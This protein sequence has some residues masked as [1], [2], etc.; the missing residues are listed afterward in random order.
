MTLPSTKRRAFISY[1]HESDAHRKAVLT[2]SQRLSSILGDTTVEII[3]DQT[4]LD[5]RPAGP[6]EGWNRWS[7]NMAA[8]AERVIAIISPGWFAAM[9]Q[10]ELKPLPGGRG[11]AV[12]ATVI[13]NR[14]TDGRTVSPWLRL[15]RLPTFP[16]TETNWLMRDI[17]VFLGDNDADIQALGRWLKNTDALGAAEAPSAST[18]LHPSKTTPPARRPGPAIAIAAGAAAL[19]AGGFF[20]AKPVLFAAKDD[21]ARDQA[22]SDSPATPPPPESTPSPKPATH[23]LPANP[24]PGALGEVPLDA[25]TTLKLRWCPP[26]QFTMGR[27]QSEIQHL[28]TFELHDK[29]EER[30][31]SEVTVPAGFWIS[32]TE[33]TRKQ[34]AAIRSSSS[35]TAT[36]SDDFPAVGLSHPDAV[37]IGAELTAKLAGS[38][39]TARLPNNAEWEYACRAGSTS[40]FSFGDAIDGTRA[41]YDA[42][43]TI[44]GSTGKKGPGKALKVGSFEN[45]RNRWQ[46]LDMHGNVSEWC[47]WGDQPGNTTAPPTSPG[48]FPTRGGNYD[49]HWINCT[50]G[51]RSAIDGTKGSPKVGL[52]LMLAPSSPP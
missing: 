29:P 10:K 38:G 15:V 17:P 46:L 35:A 26:G 22:K 14:H 13:F 40:M 50:S 1:R 39:W 43:F 21:A 42:T 5:T 49:S 47:L 51:A 44:D 7:M 23:S 41:N 4:L 34:L 24:A 12:E 28:Q 48:K 3:N 16:D 31:R 33:L 9:D 52:R 19:L 27:V 30:L 8:H 37:Q 18:P 45:E 32:E 36:E 25:T 20:L 2:F 11:S 6:D